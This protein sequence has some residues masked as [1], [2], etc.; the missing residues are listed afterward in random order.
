LNANAL[1]SFVSWDIDRNGKGFLMM[2]ESRSN[3]DGPGTI[4]V[5]LVWT[6]ELKQRVPCK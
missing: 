5:V 1:V 2:K 6:E 4:A 3:A